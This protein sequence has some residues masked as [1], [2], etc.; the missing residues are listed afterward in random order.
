MCSSAEVC[1]Y[2]EMSAP[3]DWENNTCSGK[4]EGNNI[5]STFCVVGAQI[6]VVSAGFEK[7]EVWPYSLKQ[8]SDLNFVRMFLLEMFA[9][10]GHDDEIWV[11]Y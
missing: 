6:S 8:I 9:S 3:F 11:S 10:T 2:P 4:A 1:S 5:K 7:W